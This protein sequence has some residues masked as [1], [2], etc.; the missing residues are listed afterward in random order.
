LLKCANF[1]FGI[2]F[3]AIPTSTWGLPPVCQPGIAGWTAE[4]DQAVRKVCSVSGFDCDLLPRVIVRP[5]KIAPAPL[6]PTSP[7]R[8]CPGSP[9]PLD[10]LVDLVLGGG[11]TEPGACAGCDMVA[12]DGVTCERVHIYWDPNSEVCGG[13]AQQMMHEVVHALD[14][15]FI[16]HPSDPPRKNAAG[17]EPLLED[18]AVRWENVLLSECGN[19]CCPRTDYLNCPVTLPLQNVEQFNPQG[20]RKI[21]PQTCNGRMVY[22]FVSGN[23]GY[24]DWRWG[25]FNTAFSEQGF[26]VEINPAIGGVSYPSQIATG[27]SQVVVTTGGA[28]LVAGFEVDLTWA[29]I[30]TGL[31]LGWPTIGAS[32]QVLPYLKGPP[33]T[34]YT[35]KISMVGSL[36]ADDMGVHWDGL[37]N[38]TFYPVI[39]PPPG[40]GT[41]VWDNSHPSARAGTFSGATSSDCFRLLSDGSPMGLASGDDPNVGEVFSRVGGGLPESSGRSEDVGLNKNSSLG[42]TA[43]GNV[44][45]TTMFEFVSPSIP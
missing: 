13:G 30:T 7:T 29:R 27:N 34:P 22:W 8:H 4:C 45:T 28:S 1:L 11:L 26:Q 39:G 15:S 6:S 41:T 23:L 21:D 14:N 24:S 19:G 9:S 36:S 18:L 17:C 38:N 10:Q 44:S 43:T 20:L 3:A 33:G 12:P 37:G 35:V 42:G 2:A 5:N 31:D 16:R 40:G 25:P 32:F